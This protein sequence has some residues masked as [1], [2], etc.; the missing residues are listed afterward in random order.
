M[1]I[2]HLW[3]YVCKVYKNTILHTILCVSGIV[4]GTDEILKRTSVEV[5]S[6]TDPTW[7]NIRLDRV[8]GPF[9]LQV[10]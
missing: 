4:Y 7:G 6:C 2:V 5:Q 9:L 8:W 10:L 3:L 1:H